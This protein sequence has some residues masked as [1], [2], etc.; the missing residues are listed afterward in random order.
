MPKLTER[1]GISGAMITALDLSRGLGLYCGLDVVKVP[2]ATGY[3]DTNYLGKAE[4]ALTE[5]KAKDLVYVHVGA[6]DEAGHNGDVQAKVKA[7]EAFDEYTVG[8][9][10]RELPKLGSHRILAVCNHATPVALRQ[11]TSEPVPF[12][13]YEGPGERNLGHGDRGFNELDAKAAKVALSDA[14]KLMSRLIGK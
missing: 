6:M 4:S 10:L 1:Y 11:H 3:A 7:I 9:L 5:L 13:L 14:T 2:G 12:A 8:T